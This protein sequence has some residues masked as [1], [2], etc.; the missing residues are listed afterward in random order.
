MK[1]DYL[2]DGS[3]EP[4]TEIE[5]LEGLL[6][7]YRSERP[8]PELPETPV[9]PFRPRRAVFVPYAAAAAVLLMLSLGVWTIS[10]FGGSESQ[11][12]VAGN[13]PALN[14]PVGPGPA[15]TQPPDVPPKVDTGTG[16]RDIVRV[17]TP[18]SPKLRQPKAETQPAPAPVEPETKFRPL[19]DVATAAHIQQAEILL[20]S[21][22]NAS[23]DDDDAVAEVAFDSQQSRELLDQNTLLRG[24]AKTKKNL[25][26]SQLLGD[27]EPYLIDIASLGDKPSRDDVREIQ[28]RLEQREIV[29]D[30]SLYSMNRPTQGF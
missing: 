13:P 23:T 30:L 22:R 7:R 12:E 24:A 3:G 17:S 16:T 26:A 10:R 27:I 29:D 9:V 11:P 25:V 19:V 2:W 18:K 1:D 14:P 5:K 6:G 21:F 20:R 15:P 28:Q 8:A 4:D